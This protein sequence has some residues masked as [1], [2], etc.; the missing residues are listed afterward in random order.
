MPITVTTLYLPEWPLI[1]GYEDEA[2]L[3]QITRGMA[4]RETR[5][6]LRYSDSYVNRIFFSVSFRI[7][8]LWRLNGFFFFF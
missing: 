6:G 2:R 8:L 1:A 3:L 5:M 7:S 4:P